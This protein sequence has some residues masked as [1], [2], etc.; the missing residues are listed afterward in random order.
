MKALK[1]GVVALLGVLLL[2]QAAFAQAKGIAAELP[3]RKQVRLSAL[4]AGMWTGKQPSLRIEG[5]IKQP[6]TVTARVFSSFAYLPGQQPERH[7]TAVGTITIGQGREGLTA[8]GSWRK[9]PQPRLK[10][11]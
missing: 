6:G 3:I 11:P 7:A 1:T 8:T 5:N 4:H 10:A 2:S 9:L